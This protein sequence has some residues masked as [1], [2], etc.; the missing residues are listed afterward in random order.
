MSCSEAMTLAGSD[1]PSLQ[2]TWLELAL[3][4]QKWC[5]YPSSSMHFW[6]YTSAN[7]HPCTDYT[8]GRCLVKKWTAS[9]VLLPS[10]SDKTTFHL[11]VI[12]CWINHSAAIYTVL[13]LYSSVI[14]PKTASKNEGLSLHRHYCSWHIP[15]LV[16]LVTVLK[17]IHHWPSFF[18]V[19]WPCIWTWQE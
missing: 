14:L 2:L 11:L 13:L 16:F 19:L 12:A 3:S 1:L 5:S 18:P 10:V 8:S 15:R 6:P 7:H 4:R 9:T 17:Q